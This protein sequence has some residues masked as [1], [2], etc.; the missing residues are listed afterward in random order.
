M[1]NINFINK[2]AVF[3]TDITTGSGTVVDKVYEDDVV[4]VS[5]ASDAT[6][7]T[8][9]VLALTGNTHLKPVV[10]VNGILVENLAL[11]SNKRWAGSVAITVTG[12]SPYAITATHEDGGSYT[13]IMTE[14]V[15]PAATVAFTGG[16][17]GTQTE[18]K[19]GDSFSITVS[20]DTN[21]DRIEVQ[22]YEACDYQLI[23]VAS[24]TGP[25][26]Q[27]VTIANRGAG[28]ID[29]QKVQVRCRGA[30]GIWGALATSSGVGDGTGYVKLNND[31]PV[32][33]A[34]AQGNISYPASQS[35][36]KDS[37]TATVN[38]TITVNTGAFSVVYSS[39][40]SQLTPTNPTTYEAAKVVTRADGNYNIATTNLLITATKTTNA[41]VSTRNAVV[42]IAHVA[43]TLTVATATTRLR[44]GGNQGTAA[45]NHVITITGSQNLYAAPTLV[46]PEGTW[47]GAG[48]AGSATT[49]TRSLQIHDDNTKGTYAWGAISATNLAG[50][51]TTTITTGPNYVIGGFVFRTLTV[52]A[53]P[54]RETAIG[55]AV[56]NT[57]KLQCT[58]LSKGSSG[59]LNYIFEAQVADTVDKYTITQP[60]TVYNAQGNIFRNN[61]LANSISNTSG[62]LAVEL[63]EI[64]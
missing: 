39:P 6:E 31:Y 54:N 63:E 23:T 4:L 48:F 14:A 64:V 55:T 17:P 28:A 13:T 33:S 8:V 35:A 24:G 12:D 18:L 7:I 50:K 47:Q 27:S 3:V 40:N 1:S 53:W 19:A 11:D 29:L 26:V 57:A 56:A 36:I 38:H 22:N 62:T 49:W 42:Y 25:F 30:N 21:C 44:S 58:N 46:A 10:W 45:Q 59:S 5:C 32:I 34:I 15:G 60:S 37:E 43:M 2:A 16:Y 52:A 51:V 9:A 41:A 20:T 61:D